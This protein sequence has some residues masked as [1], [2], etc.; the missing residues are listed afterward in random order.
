LLY[1]LYRDVGAEVVGFNY[2]VCFLL[3]GSVK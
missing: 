3:K 2:L 1:Q